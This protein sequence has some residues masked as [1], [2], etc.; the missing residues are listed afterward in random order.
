[1]AQEDSALAILVVVVVVAT[2]GV[3]LSASTFVTHNSFSGMMGGGKGMMNQTVSTPSTGPGATEWIV[4][5]LSGGLLGGAIVY[6]ALSRSSRRATAPGNAPPAAM[7]APAMAWPASSVGPATTPSHEPV[8]EVTL[9]KL[10]GEDEKR[11]YLEIR[12]HGGEMLQR[13]IVGLG[14]FSKAKVTRVLDKLE[15]KGLVRREAHGMTNRVRLV[16]GVPK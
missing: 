6:W 3:A 9:V 12:E 8:P 1:M 5:V 14:I 11:M 7:A 10:L 15:G 13:D 2:A 16:N 4:L